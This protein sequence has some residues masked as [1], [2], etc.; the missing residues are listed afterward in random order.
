MS[1][2]SSLRIALSGFFVV[3]MALPS[4]CFANEP[5]K[6]A[7][8]ATYDSSTGEINFAMS[9]NPEVDDSLAQPSDVVIFVDTSASQTGAYKDDSI[10]TL[11]KLLANLNAE[12]RVKVLAIDIDTVQLHNNEFVRPDANATVVA[13]EKLKER[14]PLGSTDMAGMLNSAVNHFEAAPG[15]SRNVIYIGDGV[16]A[17]LLES[18]R[19]TSAVGSL[20][21]NQISVSSFA[22]GPHR[23]VDLLAA[24][25]NYTGG[26]VV[27]D[28]NDPESTMQA[29]AELAATVHGTVFWPTQVKVPV[30]ID[31]LFPGKV[32]PLRSDRDTVV[33]GCLTERG[34]F[35][36][37]ITG[38]VNGSEKTMSWPLSPEDSSDNFAFLPKLVE[39]ARL[40]SGMTLPTVG[41]AG[42]REMARVLSVGSQQLTQMSA[43]A[44]VTG[45]FTAA[46]T[47]AAEAQLLSL[48]HI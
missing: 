12:D 5:T 14:V 7:R 38:E 22:I 19:F 24:L 37:T 42:L 4:L 33:I 2:N 34:D 20:T 46:R 25:A 35:E 32:P 48:I 9:L 30:Q 36:M 23:N 8:L 41:S 40:N 45:N 11:K 3:A 16:S 43:Q 17:G 13:I 44:A 18:N 29:G 31:E 27:L 47:L 15:R 26:N 21:R 28:S 39:M 6:A 1:K 10:K